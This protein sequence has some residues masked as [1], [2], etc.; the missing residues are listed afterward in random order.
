M[1]VVAR[2]SL[3]VVVAITG[4]SLGLTPDQTSPATVRAAERASSYGDYGAGNWP[5]GTWRPYQAGSAFNRRVSG[6]NGTR[7]PRSQSMVS[8]VLASGP[9]AKLL[10][11]TSGTSRDF[12]HPVYFARRTDP[13]YRLQTTRPWGRNVIDGARIHVPRQA[14]P[15]GGDDGH[16]TVI[17]PDG[18][19]YDLWQVQS[20]PRHRGRLRFGWG[21]RLPIEGDGRRSGAT[22]AEFGSAAGII[23]GA[24]LRAG[25]IDH[26]LALVVRCTAADLRFG[27]GVRPAARHDPGSSF[28]YPATK[29]ATVCRGGAKNAPPAG[30]RFRL[31]L[32]ER[33]LASLRAPV[34]K[35]T[36]LRALVEY[37]AYVTDTGGS[38]FS[39]L[40]ESGS[41]FTS[42]GAPDPI[43]EVAQRSGVPRVDGTY[44]LDFASGVN[45]KRDLEVVVPPRER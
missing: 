22:A 7:H 19:E 24:E 11:G 17:Q 41:S 35:R 36:I 20:G 27:F 18:M 16:M 14:R 23:R 9:P 4:L 40:M 31:R 2:G 13:V 3:A 26:A 28:V 38:G 37:G 45:W 44:A 33:Q 1:S 6:E 29:G 34:W 21:G 39:L 32:T 5:S 10:A 12:D 43:V 15:A 25:R 42:F 30:A 8:Q